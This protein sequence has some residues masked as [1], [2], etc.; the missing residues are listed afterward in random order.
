M[1]V[2][3]C[4]FRATLPIRIGIF[5]RLARDKNVTTLRKPTSGCILQA[6]AVSQ[7]VI[8]AVC[9]A[10]CE[11]QPLK[12]TRRKRYKAI[13]KKTLPMAAVATISGQTMEASAP[14]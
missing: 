9:T 5:K 12:M 14:R 7:L 10:V 3:E 6:R 8:C 13:P 11:A 2:P 4:S 1:A